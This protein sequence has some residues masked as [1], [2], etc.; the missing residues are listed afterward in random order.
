MQKRLN[1]Q[2]FHLLYIALIIIV[3]AGLGFTGWYVWD[4]NQN[5]T[6][7][8]QT[9]ST[10]TPT[11][12]E[13]VTPTPT[14]TRTNNNPTDWKTYF[15]PYGYSVKYPS[16][17]SVGAVTSDVQRDDRLI[18]FIEGQDVT[19]NRKVCMREQR[20]SE[21]GSIRVG[22]D[23]PP[24]E[25][26]FENSNMSNIDYMIV[27]ETQGMNTHGETIENREVLQTVSEE[28]YYFEFKLYV[29][30]STEASYH[31]GALMPL[32]ED[33]FL[34]FSMESVNYYAPR[35]SE[36]IQIFKQLVQTVEFY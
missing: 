5:Q 20:I 27:D 1:E 4:K 10:P 23:Y 22:D 9:N 15:S 3:I 14:I 17:W 24:Q 19:D 26:D 35:A 13:T 18:C 30:D 32:D 12:T 36:D 2:G 29:E 33:R 8:E 28:V 34:I 25:T 31:Y 21:T 6:V 7:E 11:P 16:E